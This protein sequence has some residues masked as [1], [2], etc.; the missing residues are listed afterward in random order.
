MMIR[1]SCQWLPSSVTSV[2][3]LVQRTKNG[4]GVKISWRM[5]GE[6]SGLAP[7]LSH[8]P[9]RAFFFASALCFSIAHTGLFSGEGLELI[10]RDVN[11][12]R[13]TLS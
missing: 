13:L 8:R 12:W 10:L 5:E 4:I 3:L 11:D 9:P 2:P 6:K 1:Y 7:F